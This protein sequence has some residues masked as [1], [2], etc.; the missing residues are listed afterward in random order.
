MN[1][2]VNA[3]RASTLPSLPQSTRSALLSRFLSGGKQR[4]GGRELKAV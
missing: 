2:K 1:L 3:V 4:R